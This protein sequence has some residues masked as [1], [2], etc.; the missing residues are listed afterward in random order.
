MAN[1]GGTVGASVDIS[2]LGPLEV[3]VGGQA[4]PVQGR[5]QKALFGLL[6]LSANLVIPTETLLEELWGEEQPASGATALQVRIS[7]LRRALGPAGVAIETRTPGYAMR[8]APEQVDSQ[9]FER[10]LAEGAALLADARP[11][12]AA[13][14]LREALALW[15]GPALADLA[16]ERFAQAEIARLEELRLLA[17]EERA[18]ADLACGRHAELVA[19]LE[20]LV[21]AHPVRERFRAQLMLALYRSSRQAD[22]LGSYREGRDILVGE[23]G[24]EPG[25]RL[26]KLERAI[27]RQDPAIAGR[28]G[29]ETPSRPAT[30]VPPVAASEERKVVTVLFVDP[31]ASADRSASGDPERVRARRDHYHDAMAA[32]I[33][34]A[35]GIF[36]RL[37]SGAMMAAFGA[38]VAQEDHAERALHVAIALRKRLADLGDELVSLR[39]GVATGEVVVSTTP[40][41]GSRLTGSAVGDRDRVEREA[42][43]LV[44]QGGYLEPFA[45]RA[46]GVVRE[47]EA[48][49]RQAASRFE[50]LGLGWHASKTRK[51]L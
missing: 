34:S 16:F 4:L 40:A 47:D 6:L 17:L 3:R 30:T 48:L 18:E 8:V 39:A 23:L 50:A 38:P 2:V 49:L 19:E 5:R 51:L 26:R 29:V 20:A 45:L 32:E 9:R 42:P 35:G 13:G 43:A 10:A 41:G 1:A 15:R 22:A 28:P 33:D 31:I 37:P 14:R 24:I 25:E 12:D 11:L 21:A 27:L 36:E 46:L 44:R 7:Q